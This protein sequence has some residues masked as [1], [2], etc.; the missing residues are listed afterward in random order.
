MWVFFFVLLVAFA[1]GLRLWLHEPGIVFS[2][3]HRTARLPSRRDGR[4]HRD[5]V[6]HVRARTD[7][8]AVPRC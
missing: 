8:Q 2:G 5:A 7:A 6:G 4:M 1:I 3:H